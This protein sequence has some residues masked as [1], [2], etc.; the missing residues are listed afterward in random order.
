MSKYARP[1]IIGFIVAFVIG[2]G[3]SFM[4][5]AAGGSPGLAPTIVGGVFG[6][7]TAY[8]LANLVGTKAGK[9]ADPALKSAAAGFRPEPGR[10]MLIVLREGFVGM[11]AGVNV[12]VDGRVVA[13]LKSPRFT[14]VPLDVGSHEMSLSFGGLAGAQNN[15]VAERFGVGAGEVAVYRATVAMGAMKN[16]IT[17]QRLTADA[18]LSD[19]LKSMTM[20]APEV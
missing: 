15:T 8:I 1:L 19:K 14:A 18:A 6:A 16:S 17:L 20:T 5:S 11:A 7:L 2:G 3:L 12:S 4:I 9:A 10:A 13:Q